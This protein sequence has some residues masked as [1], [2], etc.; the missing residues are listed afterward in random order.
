MTNHSELF[1][2]EP[3]DPNRE[4]HELAREAIC[5]FLLWTGDA[6][7]LADRGLRT[8]VAL[9]CL[10]PDLIQGATLEELGFPMGLTRQTVHRMVVSFRES[11]GLKS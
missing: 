1:F 4:A 6:P 7:T 3:A 11:F 5:R 9:Y 10:R 2:N 8:S